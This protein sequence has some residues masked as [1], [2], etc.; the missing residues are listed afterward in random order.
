MRVLLLKI[1]ILFSIIVVPILMFFFQTRWNLLHKLFCLLS[2][3]ATMIFGYITALT[4]YNIIIDQTVFMTNVH[5]VFLNPIFLLA[6]AYI[7]LFITYHF[8]YLLFA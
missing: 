1:F 6:G 5:A 2:I 8:I 3:I 4:I 7:G